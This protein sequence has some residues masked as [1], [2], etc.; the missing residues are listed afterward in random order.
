M[1]VIVGVHNLLSPL[2]TVNILWNDWVVIYEKGYQ[3]TENLISICFTKVKGFLVKDYKQDKKYLPQIWDNAEIVYP[4]LEQGAILIITNTI[5]TPQQSPCIGKPA[6]GNEFVCLSN[7]DCNADHIPFGG[8]TALTGKCID[9]V[10][11]EG[12]CEIYSWCPL[13]NDTIS[14]DFNLQNRFD[15]I[16]NYTIYIKVY[17]EY[18]RFGIKLNNKFDDVDI[19]KCQFDRNDPTNKH[20][21]IFKLGYIFDEIKLKPSALYKGGVIGILINWDC[22]LD[23]GFIGCRPI[24][25][26]TNLQDG[27]TEDGFNYRYAIKYRENGKQ[28]RDLIKAYGLRFTLFVSGTAG[29]FSF[30]KL[31]LNIGSGLGLLAFTPVVFDIILLTCLKTREIYKEAK[32]ETLKEDDIKVRMKATQGENHHIEDAVDSITQV[33]DSTIADLGDIGKAAP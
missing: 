2:L 3:D 30:I 20:C 29:R 22:N 17:I 19:T 32:F 11:G 10:N 23:F 14:I 16:S 31:F 7:S 4:P 27:T 28:Y 12:V 25:S 33:A 6:E 9:M 18:R 26:F 21:P 13:E 1:R 24:Y 8:F 15:M 5:E